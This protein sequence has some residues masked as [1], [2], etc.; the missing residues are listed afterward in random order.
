MSSELSLALGLCIVGLVVLVAGAEMLVRGGSALAGRLKISPTIIGLTVIAI[1]TSAPEL[2]VGVDASLKGN[3]ELA[4][5]NIAGTNTVNILLILGLSAL[6]K[7]LHLQKNTLKLDLPA[8][9]VAAIALYALSLDGVLSWG[10]GVILIALGLCYS[11]LLWRAALRERAAATEISGDTEEPSG[12]GLGG[13]FGD[14]GLLVGGIVIVVLGAD[15]LV[16]GGV[17]VA[18]VWGVSDAFIGLTIV[19]IGTSAPELVTTI[20]STVR[21]KREIAIGNLLGSSTYNIAFILGM[22]CLVPADG[23]SVPGD[24]LAIDIP[25][26]MAAIL[27]CL[28]VFLIGRYVS[29]WEGALFV[30][31]YAAYLASLL[32]TR[33]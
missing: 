13:V 5:G 22:T 27:A 16:T 6:I 28:P 17:A 10:D 20:V 21:G 24:V 30:T 31:A 11:G 2:A 32:I 18:E 26:M 33:T 7:P 1:G 25:V 9:L 8:M 12:R 15:W 14:A 29:R 19:A 23:L 3:G 4:I